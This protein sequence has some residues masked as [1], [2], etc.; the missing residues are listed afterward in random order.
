MLIKSTN[1]EFS[2]YREI[3]IDP[4]FLKDRALLELFKRNLP[5]REAYYY[6]PQGEEVVIFNKKSQKKPFVEYI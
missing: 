5:P 2:R 4:F 1:E 6:F 3:L